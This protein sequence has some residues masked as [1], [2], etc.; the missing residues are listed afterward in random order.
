VEEI[1]D[2]ESFHVNGIVNLGNGERSKDFQFSALPQ[3]KLFI[4]EFVG[5]NAFAQPGQVLFAA[6]QVQ[7]NSVMG[8]YPIVLTGSSPFPDS[9]YPTRIF[10]SQQLRLYA[11]PDSCLIVTVDRNTD[12]SK[13]A[14]VE[15][16]LSGRIIVP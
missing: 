15:F 7:T 5:I 12:S 9:T 13:D 3:G 11:D 2:G 10:G 14:R 1:M 4:I 16:H 8:V 6:L